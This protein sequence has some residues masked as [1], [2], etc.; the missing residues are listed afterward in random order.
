MHADHQH[1]F[2]LIQL[3]PR[4]LN[5]PHGYVSLKKIKANLIHIMNNHNISF[6]SALRHW[7]KLRK[8]SQLE[9]ALNADVSQRHISW[10][11]T[12]RS[13]PS[14]EMVIKLSEAMDIP[15]RD[16]NHLLNLSLIH[17]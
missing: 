15:L 13:H 16:R 5:L 7:R 1:L 3:P 10:L 11:E 14:K 4:L 2:L 8:V 9:L 17:I 12:G 6:N